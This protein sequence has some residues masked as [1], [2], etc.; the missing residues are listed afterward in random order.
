MAVKLNKDMIARDEY[1]NRLIA[2]KDKRVVKVITGIRRCGK[3]TLLMLYADWLRANGVGEEQIVSINLES[4][5]YDDVRDHKA[6]YNAVSQKMVTAAK[7]YVLLDEVQNVAEFERATESLSLDYDVDI[8]ITGSNAYMLSSELATLL[9]GRYVEV[10]LLP[11]SF[12]EYCTAWP[13][14]NLDRLF[15][16]YMKYGGFPF[17]AD[18]A[19]ENIVN[20]YLDGIY[21]TVVLKD[22][23][24]RNGVRDITLL[25]N[26][27]KM[28]LSAI[29]SIVSP[30]SIV[31]SLCS[32]GRQVSNETVERYLDM[33]CNAFILSKAVRYDIKGKAY[34]KTLNKYYVTDLGLRNNVLGYR[35]IE[36]TH[37][38]EN[39]V[40]LEL[41]R[42]GYK[43]DIG[44]MNDSEIDFVA[45]KQDTV[46]YYQVSYTVNNSPE[47]LHR[48]IRPFDSINDHYAR[49]L[50]TMDRD[51]VTDIDGIRKLNVVD[52]L[53]GTTS[54]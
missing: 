6:L 12:A 18:I 47:T 17:L 16:R 24:K 50:I 52:W 42:R 32:E 36:P 34:L 27:L 38:L 4:A 44:K 26:V 9:S 5:L 28:V 2:F 29:G 23:I 7:H 43:V 51:L 22:I 45:R 10:A 37:A 39:I 8:Y 48:E 15:V 30:S 53:I 33:F 19:D 54:S 13:D 31:K 11:L 3:S 20:S 40:Y 46:E 21:N 14:E 49:Y 1:L 41:L 35:Q 25:E